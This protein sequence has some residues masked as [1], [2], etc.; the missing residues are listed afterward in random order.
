MVR[1]DNGK[2]KLWTEEIPVDT[3][4]HKPRR[5]KYLCPMFAAAAKRGVPWG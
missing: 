3:Y 2:V 4:E 1:Q 5:E